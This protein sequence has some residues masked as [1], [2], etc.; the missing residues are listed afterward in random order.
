V[1]ED[2]SDFP[3]YVGISAD[4][5]LAA[6][7][8]PSGADIVF[9]DADGMTPLD[10]EIERF[11]SSTGRLDAWVRLPLLSST[12]D[13]RIYL[14]YGNPAA[15]TPGASS[16]VWNAQY[17]GVWHLAQEPGV[18]PAI[19]DSTGGVDLTPAGAMTATARQTGQL[20]WA[21]DFDGVDD[22]LSSA[23]EPRL[24]VTNLTITAW[25]QARTFPGN[26]GTIV[27][28][29]TMEGA[30]NHDYFLRAGDGDL[31]FGVFTGASDGITWGGWST[32][33]EWH[34]LAATYDG[35]LRIYFDGSEVA[36]DPGEG[37]IRDSMRPF[38]IGSWGVP[39]A[40]RTWNGLI[41]E[42]RISSV[43]RSASWIA[44]RHANERDAASFLVVGGEDVRP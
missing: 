32:T 17:V 37:L 14:Y 18:S 15:P 43:A 16:E 31:N 9:T 20:G 10:F 41:D 25:V 13:T 22:R 34:S 38:H 36:T 42:V 4:G 23:V 21:I 44:T 29:S 12:A 28:R 40:T 35:T 2:L 11:D 7:A 26:T 30:S 19:V 8:S 33:G 27:A 39:D 5:S 3:A 1:A 24:A 6:N